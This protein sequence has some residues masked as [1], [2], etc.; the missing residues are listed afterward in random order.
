[1]ARAINITYAVD[2]PY[3]DAEDAM[4][5]ELAALPNDALKVLYCD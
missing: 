1:M 4:D 2:S 3:P 5:R